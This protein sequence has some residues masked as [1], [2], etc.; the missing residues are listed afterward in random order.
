MNKR[1]ALQYHPNYILLKVFKRYMTRS[2]QVIFESNISGCK[3]ENGKLFTNRMLKYFN[4]EL[5]KTNPLIWQDIWI[6]NYCMY[7]IKNGLRKTLLL[8]RYEQECFIQSD[9]EFWETINKNS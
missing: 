9:V 7:E 8:K 2:E 6:Y 5:L 3:S 4:I 1:K